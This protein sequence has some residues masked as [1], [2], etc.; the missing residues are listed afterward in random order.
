MPYVGQWISTILM[1]LIV[2]KTL[3]K[4]LISR[5][6]VRKLVVTFSECK[7]LQK[8]YLLNTCYYINKLAYIAFF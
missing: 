7:I 4:N 6:N 2:D 8:V 5:T 3:E 1:S